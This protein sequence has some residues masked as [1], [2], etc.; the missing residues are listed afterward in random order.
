MA[1]PAA[2]TGALQ[3]MVRLGVLEKHC[4]RIL[5][6]KLRQQPVATTVQGNR[7]LCIV[8]TSMLHKE[9]PPRACMLGPMGSIALSRLL[10][11]ARGLLLRAR[12]AQRV[13]MMSRSSWSSATADQQS[14]AAVAPPT[15]T[16]VKTHVLLVSKANSS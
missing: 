12:R 9:R 7:Y 13:E 3:H 8:Y 1:F 16:K 10:G 2:H 6:D 5:V 4:A 11:D 14:I 15:T